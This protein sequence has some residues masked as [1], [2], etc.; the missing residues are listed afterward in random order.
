MPTSIFIIMRNN[1]EFTIK[2]TK[3]S[4]ILI[5]SLDSDNMVVSQIKYRFRNA[6]TEGMTLEEACKIVNRMN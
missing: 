2:Q 5:D 4:K 3:T 6:E 1:I